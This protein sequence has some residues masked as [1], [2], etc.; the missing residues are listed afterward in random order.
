MGRRRKKYRKMSDA[1]K[2]QVV[3]LHRMG[4]SSWEIS[5]KLK[6]SHSSIHRLIEKAKSSPLLQLV[7]DN[8]DFRQYFLKKI[9]VLLK[10]TMMQYSKMPETKAQQKKALATAIGVLYDK[11][12]KAQTHISVYRKDD[13]E[14]MSIGDI[15]KE[16]KELEEALGETEDTEGSA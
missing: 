16:I 1:E 5:K 8:S 2:I 3:E 15:R 9:V 11:W 14:S 4:L 6:F 12:E 10:E 7:D 13:I